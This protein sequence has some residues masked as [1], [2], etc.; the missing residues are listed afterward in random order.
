MYASPVL[1]SDDPIPL[2]RRHNLD[3]PMSAEQEVFTAMAVLKRG[4]RSSADALIAQLG[5]RAGCTLTLRF[6]QKAG[7][8][9]GLER[10]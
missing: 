2:G 3:W 8:L 6:D 10:V 9:P 4:R 1:F 7:W 5:A